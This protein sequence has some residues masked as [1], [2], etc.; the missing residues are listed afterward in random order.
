MQNASVVTRIWKV[1][2]GHPGRSSVGG[3][4]PKLLDQL[5]EALRSRHYSRQTEQ[6]YCMWFKRFIYF[7]NIR[8]PVDGL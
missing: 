7:H 5:R 2:E 1:N 6:T 4:K 8:S 3:A